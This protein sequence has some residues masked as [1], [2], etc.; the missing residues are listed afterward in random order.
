MKRRPELIKSLVGKTF[1]RLTALECILKPD[2]HGTRYRCLC[3]CGSEVIVGRG[4]L[5]QG[6][7][8]SCGCLRSD[9]SRAREVKKN[10]PTH[11]TVLSYYKKNAKIRNL[12]WELNTDEFTELISGDCFYCGSAPEPRVLI[13]KTIS[14]NGIDRWD[15]SLGYVYSN[16]V[17]CCTT[18]NTAKMNK[19]AKEFLQ[20]AIRISER[21]KAAGIHG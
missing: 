20:W 2:G 12:A 1:G 19:T 15:N 21:L 10:H 8:K 18:C 5:T 14:F 6:N 16:C 9:S 11:G 7:T 3:S 17:S 4:N 13:G